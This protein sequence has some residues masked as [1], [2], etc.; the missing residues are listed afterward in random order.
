M[1]NELFV[2]IRGQ[3]YCFSIEDILEG[4]CEKIRE[5]V[6]EYPS[7]RIIINRPKK[8][9]EAILD[10]HLTG[11]LH[12]PISTCPEEFKEELDFWEI[13]H[14]KLERCC[15]NRLASYYREKA[16]LKDY[17]NSGTCMP[18]KYASYPKSS[19]RKVFLKVWNVLNYHDDCLV[20]K[21]YFFVSTCFILLSIFGVA[22]STLP[23]FRVKEA[24]PETVPT[25]ST[26]D[27]CKLLYERVTSSKSL[28]TDLNDSSI[29][30]DGSDFISSIF[31]ESV[32][33]K[34]PSLQQTIDQGT[35]VFFYIEIATTI[36]FTAEQA[37]RIL[38]CPGLLSYT[39]GLM[40]IVEILL[41][42]ASYCRFILH[43]LEIQYNGNAWSFLLYV[44]M[45]RVLR[46]V[47]VMRHV[48]AFKVLNYSIKVGK[49]DLC[50]IIMYIFIGLMIF[51]NLVFF[52]ELSDDFRSIPD[53]WWWTLITM[54]TVGYGDIIPK[55]IAGKVLGCVCAVSGVIMLSLV[56]PIFVN[57]FLF[58]YQFAEL[59]S[60]TI[61]APKKPC[62]LKRKATPDDTEV[63]YTS[64]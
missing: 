31:P 39:C 38:T 1:V 16:L 21:I 6:R 36:F 10:F 44:Q 11:I 3:K 26:P 2:Y 48:L 51:S 42:M 15:L 32:H 14:E 29:H 56:I 61:P 18:E 62:E 59:E 28:A 7:E 12:M 30:R 55:T 25:I 23:Q 17:K 35:K 20:A 57:T 64:E 50:I 49:K 22:I 27:Y 13:S 46:I 43:F 58:L 60:V 33:K 52:F 24:P 8:A 63:T 19:P 54:T 41:L 40:N 9:F 53:A 45:F 34:I 47:R 37:M 5:W 4:H